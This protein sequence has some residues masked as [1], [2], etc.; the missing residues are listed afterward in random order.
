MFCRST[1]FQTVYAAL[2]NN[3]YHDKLAVAFQENGKSASRG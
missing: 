3:A 2:A 1:D